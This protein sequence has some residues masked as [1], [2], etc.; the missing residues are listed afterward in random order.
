MLCCLP[1]P[2]IY[3]PQRTTYRNVWFIIVSADTFDD[4]NSRSD[5]KA[6]HT[7]SF[8]AFKCLLYR[9]LGA[10]IAS[11]AAGPS[12][13]LLLSNRFPIRKSETEPVADS[14]EGISTGV[15]PDFTPLS[16]SAEIIWGCVV[17][18]NFRRTLLRRPLYPPGRG[19]R[20]PWGTG[21]LP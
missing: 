17:I 10:W 6:R 12:I 9:H 11:H 8:W 13:I 16:V 18:G 21:E 1:L 2:M 4:N 14:G 3:Q 15:V 19:L 20:K 7:M 5:F